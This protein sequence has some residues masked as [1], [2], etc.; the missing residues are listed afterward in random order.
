MI[1]NRH[2][3]PAQQWNKW[4][5]AQRRH[6]NH[7]MGMFQDQKIINCHPNAVLL[8]LDSWKTVI[9]NCAFLAAGGDIKA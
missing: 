5:E 1:E 7:C 3:V 9:W 4:N 2:K 8:S 6:F